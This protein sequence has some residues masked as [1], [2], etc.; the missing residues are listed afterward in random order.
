MKPMQSAFTLK[1][2]ETKLGSLHV[3][4]V[5]NVE[6]RYEALEN[7]RVM[8]NFIIGEETCNVKDYLLALKVDG[9]QCF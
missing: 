7:M 2:S 5:K 6:A 4:D 3:S 1:N 9:K 8:E